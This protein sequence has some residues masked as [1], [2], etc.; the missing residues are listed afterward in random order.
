LV[1]SVDNFGAA[2][3]KPTHPELLDTLAIQ[4]QADGWSIKRLIRRLVTSRAYQM[5]SGGDAALVK[6]NQALDPDN[7]FLWRA[8]GRRLDV[9]AMRDA[10]LSISGQ[11]DRARGGPTLTFTGRFEF[12][13]DTKLLEVPN[14]SLRRGVYLPIVR[15]H[16]DMIDSLDI[17]EVFDFANPSFVTGRRNSTTV[18][19]QAL[20]LMNSPFVRSQAEQ[21]ARRLADRQ[22]SDADRVQWFFLEALGRQASDSEI[23]T[24]IAFLDGVDNRPKGNDSDGSDS[25]GL[26]AWT[27]FC[28]TIFASNE[29]V[30]L[31]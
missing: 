13:D 9:E 27:L 6:Q 17:L 11:L 4:F 19:S 18:P 16:L 3:V 1:A 29:F 14:P 5:A 10:I 26:T 28:Q 22:G 21:A 24:A 30:F 2:G 23:R 20:Y 8:R 25:T 12:A 7:N 15:D 31:N